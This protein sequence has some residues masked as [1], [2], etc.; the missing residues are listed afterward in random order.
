MTYPWMTLSVVAWMLFTAQCA[1]QRIVEGPSDT[2]A[3]LGD[4][5]LLK[6][7]VESQQG[8][9]QWVK[10]G[11]GLGNERSLLGFPRYSME[12]SVSAGEYNLRITGVEIED[13]D[14][15]EC[16]I[17][18]AGSNPTRISNAAK[19]S[20]LVEPDPP[21]LLGRASKL[22]AVAGDRV[23]QSCMSKGGK[24][25]AKIGWMIARDPKGLSLVA[26]FGDSKSKYSSKTDQQIASQELMDAD[27]TESIWKSSEN[28]FTVISNIS[29]TPIADH[30]GMYLVCFANHE[31]Y[32][33]IKTH[34]TLLDL[35]FAP[36]VEIVISNSSILKEHGS[37]VLSCEVKAK[38]SENIQI[39]WLNNGEIIS[40][41]TS[42]VVTI[43]NIGVEHHKS[44]Y[45][46][47]A[48]NEIGQ[49]SDTKI[50]N[51]AYGPRI[52]SSEQHVEISPGE[53]ASFVCEADGNPT[54]EIHWT[55][56]G[57]SDVLARG[58][59]FT[60]DSTQAW[61]R[62][63]YE[64]VASVDGFEPVRLLSFLH[65]KGPPSVSLTE[66]IVAYN[67]DT[68]EITCEIRGRPQPHDVLW[69]KNSQSLEYGRLGGRVQVHQVPR[70]FGIESRLV[71]QGIR[72]EDYGV[73]NCT[74]V[75]ELG[76]DFQIMQLKKKSVISL[77]TDAL[78]MYIAIP[79]CFL[80]LTSTMI[81]ICF[82]FRQ[83][84]RKRCGKSAKF[85]DERSDVTVKC[86]ALDGGQFFPEMYASS[87]M[88]NSDVICSK[89]YVS[90]PQN[91]PDLDYL[92]PP[93]FVGT[94]YHHPYLASTIDYGGGEHLPG[95]C[96][97]SSYGSFVSGMNTP[98]VTDIYTYN[99]SKLEVSPLETLTEVVTP[100]IDVA[101][102]LINSGIP[103]LHER[104]VSRSS[105][106]V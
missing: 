26:W 15:Y 57:S 85:S 72:D 61:Q 32:R 27:I 49:S 70:Q 96:F 45:T 77:I 14:L 17:Q 8:A 52:T 51:I 79:F 13:D 89:D 101:N 19:L 84:R 95:V 56:A 31:A 92:P 60:I 91:N 25:P 59:N 48:S 33:T 62:G 104:P 99:P 78:P 16:Q 21:K 75:N 24:P 4:T 46:C 98:S 36:K 97:G 86:E 38:P 7:R 22:K 18:A 44:K 76:N 64:C 37:V 54:P 68:V 20:V 11:Y 3:R 55:K 41:A 67:G 5:V 103:S 94:N 105:T 30:D 53:Q 88:E 50:L 93:S 63:E 71:I 66:E 69:Q 12:G 35:S 28:L 10:N 34:A 82:I 2:S 106:H 58:N 40:E 42:K 65:I 80:A 23:Y 1:Q 87:T 102:S 83:H 90:I 74:A 9:V 100:D 6:C 81:L 39:A 73:Y 43:P 47:M 29:F